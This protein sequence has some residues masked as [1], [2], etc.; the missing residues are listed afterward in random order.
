MPSEARAAL[1]AIVVVGDG[2]VGLA[3][4]IALRRAV[5]RAAVTVVPC[6]PDPSAIADR[7]MT[8]LPRTDVFHERFGLEQ[9]GFIMRAGASHRLGVRFLNWQQQNASYIHAYGAGSVGGDSV[10][11][12][13][14]DANRFAYPTDDVASPL[15]DIDY[16]LRYSQPTY[17][18]RLAALASHLGVHLL[19][20]PMTAA[21]P[22][23]NGGI[24]HILL[25]NGQSLTADIFVDCSGPQALLMDATQQ[26]SF[27][28]WSTML[29]CDR[30]MLAG[31]PAAPALSVTDTIEAHPFGWRS[32]IFGR[33]GTHH[34]FACNANIGSEADIASGLGQASG[35]V[36]KLEPGRL[37]NSW[38]GNVIAFG[39]AATRFEPLHWINLALA[40]E[41]ILLFLELLPGSD[42]D[43]LE[44]A[45]YNRRAGAMADR[46]R[47][48]IGLH[49]CAPYPPEGPF[50][51][52]AASL[53][54][55]SALAL[56]LS[57]FAKRGRLPFFEDETLPR[58]AWLSAMD[59][60]GISAGLNAQSRSTPS[61]VI[62]DRLNKQQMRSAKALELAA[63]YPGWLK[64]H[65]E[66]KK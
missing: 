66:S 11:Q 34:A 31:A 65:I 43:A 55:S 64:N 50:W 9:D 36:V 58:N 47:D 40:H 42:I 44:R 29:P 6:Q 17:R 5:P 19:A 32:T 25:A 33:D 20:L 30:V 27:Q 39:D 60:I 22:D 10:N 16:A 41:Q 63:P 13:L 12:A 56:T 46:V 14:A 48:Y 26:A 7:S 2:Q 45:E 59:C 24:G 15:S 18:N 3:A 51:R 4:A 53:Q 49:Y 28:S 8:S 57:Q 37:A 21:A 38:V 54:R 62:A 52:H 1:N 35:E 23:G 61:E